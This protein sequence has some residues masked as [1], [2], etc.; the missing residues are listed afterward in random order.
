MKTIIDVN[1]R[2]DFYKMA[3]FVILLILIIMILFYI[4]NGLTYA[5]FRIEPFNVGK[6]EGEAEPDIKANTNI[7]LRDTYSRRNNK[8]NKISNVKGVVTIRTGSV[9]TAWKITA[10]INVSNPESTIVFSLYDMVKKEKFGTEVV[11]KV[12]PPFGGTALISDYIQLPANS[13]FIFTLQGTANPPA[14]ISTS[15]TNQV[16]IQQVRLDGFN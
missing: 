5:Y 2:N 9:P 14:F 4:F 6:V 10:N 8:G 16:L 3:L 15:T 11:I 1:H 7:P 13:T 12:V